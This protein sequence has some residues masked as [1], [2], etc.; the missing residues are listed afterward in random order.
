MPIFL[1]QFIF[2]L[3]FSQLAWGVPKIPD[4]ASVGVAAAIIYDM[5]S[6]AIL[7][8]QNADEPIPPASLTKIMSMFLAWD[9]INAGHA[10]LQTPVHISRAAELAGGSSMGLKAGETVPLGK[11]LLGMAVSSGNDASHAVGEFVGGSV[12]AFVKMMNARAASLGMKNSHFSNPHGMPASDQL[13]T[14]RDMLALA[15]AYLRAHPQSLQLHNTTI[16]E[17][18]G[19]RTWNKNPLLNQYPGADGLKT[20]WVRASGHNLV[21]TA[22]KNGKRLLGVILGAPDATVRAAEACRLLD[23]G[24]LVCEN[25]Q[26]SVAAALDTIPLELNRIDALKTGR[27]AGLLRHKI[28]PAKRARATRRFLANSKERPYTSQ[29]PKPKTVSAK[30][31]SVSKKKQTTRTSGKRKAHAA[32]KGA[33]ARRS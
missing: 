15:R 29:L 28:T 9:H 20:G 10:T 5:E 24:F 3:V 18:N 17:H 14:A 12:E 7:F 21:F 23:A 22:T 4:D 11:L 27:D 19:K 33:S 26:V 2:A 6:E 8:E 13:V 16:I 1:A 30:S 31:A 32:R 25:E